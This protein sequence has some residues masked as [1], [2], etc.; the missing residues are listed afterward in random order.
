MT[1]V[2]CADAQTSHG[3]RSSLTKSEVF[4]MMT[5][6]PTL[7]KLINDGRTWTVSFDFVSSTAAFLNS[8]MVLSYMKSFIHRDIRD[9]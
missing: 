1:L 5:R 3:Y 8:V 4:H 2:D 6:V 9:L 7:R